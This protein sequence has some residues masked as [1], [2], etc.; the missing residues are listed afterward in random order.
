METSPS[1]SSTPSKPPVVDYRGAGASPS[2]EQPR[3]WSK[4]SAGEL[5]ARIC[6]V[7]LCCLAIA[8]L[9]IFLGGFFASLGQFL[10]VAAMGTWVIGSIVS[11]IG[12]FESPEVRSHVRLGCGMALACA[13]AFPVI[14]GLMWLVGSILYA[15]GMGALH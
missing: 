12:A 10:I 6:G 8:V 13:I 4:R 2:S 11:I 7:A 1:G 3:P 14:L 5:A 15:R 9:S